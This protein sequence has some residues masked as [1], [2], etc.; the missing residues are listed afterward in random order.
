MTGGPER[1]ADRG[2]I[3][4]TL[5]HIF[6]QYLKVMN[7][8]YIY[9][10]MLYTAIDVIDIKEYDNLLPVHQSKYGSSVQLIE[11]VGMMMP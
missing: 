10:R 8:M 5:S 3:P 6:G 7:G 11:S 2:I 1:Y 9:V 4:R